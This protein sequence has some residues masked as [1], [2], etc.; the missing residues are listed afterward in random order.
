M[1]A[2]SSGW[3]SPKPAATRRLA[4]T[5]LAIRNFTT[6]MARADDSSQLSLKR[7][8]P[9]SGLSSVW[10]STR[11]TQLI[12][13]GISFCNSMIAS[14]SFFISPLPASLI[15]SEPVGNSTS[16][17]NTKRSPTMR[18]FSRSDRISRSRPKKSER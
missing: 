2:A 3:N 5:P 17:W 1:S 16:D 13:G 10:P 4:G 11:S 12:S 7:P 8:V 18:M 14:A 9:D 6:D 15:S